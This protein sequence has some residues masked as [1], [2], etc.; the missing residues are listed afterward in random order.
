MKSHITSVLVHIGI[1]L[2]IWILF[3]NSYQVNNELQNIVLND[4][5]PNNLINAQTLSQEN[6]DNLVFE[7]NA[8]RNTLFPNIV[9]SIPQSE[10]DRPE[11]YQNSII[12]IVKN[13]GLVATNF[14]Y[15]ND[16][17]IITFDITKSES[18]KNK[19]TSMNHSKQ[20]VPPPAAPSF[21]T[22]KLFTNITKED[23][24][25]LDSLVNN[26]FRSEDEFS[27]IHKDS[28]LL[29]LNNYSDYI[30]NKEISNDSERHY[31][32]DH[33]YTMDQGGIEENPSNVTNNN[34]VEI[35]SA[36]KKTID[37]IN[38]IDLFS[39][40]NAK[41]YPQSEEPLADEYMMN[42]AKQATE[43]QILPLNLLRVGGY[44]AI[45]K[46][47]NSINFSDI[48]IAILD[49]GINLHEDLN[50]L[51]STQIS[52]IGS[53]DDYSDNCGHGTHVAGIAGAKDNSKGI[54][55]VVP[56][57]KLWNIKVM[58]NETI[59]NEFTLS[60]KCSATKDSI[61]RGLEYVL[62]H[63]KEIDV[64]NLSLG[65][66]CDPSKEQL[67]NTP[68]F[69][70]LLKAITSAGIPVVVAA[71]NGINDKPDDVKHWNPA[72]LGDAVTVSNF[73]DSDGKCGGLGNT[74]YRGNDDYFANNSNFNVGDLID[75]TSPGVKIL[76][77]S[78]NGGYEF[79]SGTSM[80]APLV[81][82]ALALSKAKSIDSGQDVDA[83]ILI[84][85]LTSKAIEFGTKCDGTIN[86]YIEGGRLDNSPEPVLNILKLLSE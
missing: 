9:V 79:K 65:A 17:S 45:N 36:V 30:T 6:S 69:S 16:S 76:S 18:K 62:K 48:D 70:N 28:P 11:K 34:L 84:A 15:S 47:K 67:C 7:D 1:M 49:T 81:S 71:G 25:S 54:I 82:G 38:S 50:I 41:Y 57:A 23:K 20:Y 37:D 27:L 83:S 60:K 55:G 10:K 73:V 68:T 63:R 4:F 77:T 66:I 40:V 44:D 32:N 74:T 86:G 19:F 33:T 43:K 53:G 2:I 78:K 64:V 80:S 26:M 72:K 22:S 46:F 61:K 59:T 85:D 3:I 35:E 21:N 29:L 24:K 58:E 52:F 13:N 14:E 75:I 39:E 12:D 8:D 31:I 56:G 42:L 5:F 51:N